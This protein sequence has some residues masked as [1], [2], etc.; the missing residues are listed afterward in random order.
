MVEMTDSTNPTR[1]SG[2]N[3]W[4]EASWIVLALVAISGLVATFSAGTP[5]GIASVDVFWRAVFGAS[6]VYVGARSSMAGSALAA[7]VG[8]LVPAGWI[9][10]LL[11]VVGLAGTGLGYRSSTTPQNSGLLRAMLGA[12]T[13][14]SLLRISPVGFHGL[15]ALVSAV[16]VTLLIVETQSVRTLWRHRVI[17]Q[18]AIGLAV[19]LGLFLSL[20]ALATEL[21]RRDVGSALAAVERGTEAVKD[22]DQELATTE[23]SNAVSRFGD[24]EGHFNS[25]WTQPIRVVPILNQHRQALVVAAAQGKQISA[26]T[27]A[28]AEAA[29]VDEITSGNGRIDLD[30][31]RALEDPVIAALATFQTARTEAQKINSPWLLSPVGGRL[32]E[33]IEEINDVE[34]DLNTAIQA[35]AQL[36]HILGGDGTR[37]Y[38]VIFGTP[39]EA[40]ELGGVIG[41]FAEIEVTDGVIRL[42][43]TGRNSDL[44][45]ASNGYRL[46]PADYPAR[47]VAL[48]PHTYAQNF[49]AS[50]DFPTVARAIAELYPNMGGSPIDGV[51]YLDPYALQALLTFTGPIEMDGVETVLD[52]E[53]AANFLLREQY[54]AFPDKSRRVDFLTEASKTAFERLLNADIPGPREIHDVLSPMVDQERLLFTTFVLPEVEWLNEFGVTGELRAGDSGDFLAVVNSNR[55]AN[56]LDAYMHRAIDYDVNVDPASGALDAKVTVELTNLVVPGLP[57]YVAGVALVGREF[58]AS[59]LDVSIYSPHRLTEVRIDGQIVPVEVLQE[60]GL[61]RYIVLAT[62]N[63]NQTVTVEFVLDGTIDPGSEYALEIATQPLVHDDKFSL[64]VQAPGWRTDPRDS[65]LLTG[66]FVLREKV[67]GSIFFVPDE[68]DA[69]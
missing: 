2:Q 53:T 38:L 12:V 67:Q 22:G 64:T 29:D 17:R 55:D 56:K 49:T 40:R 47:Y 21:G 44:N 6:L 41:N 33:L 57:E 16:L 15:S 23:L 27:L 25:W 69:G 14:Q 11:C 7:V 48:A 42:A 5:T 10:R 31:V 34:P 62:I 28:V 65:T 32:D 1:A 19:V 35:V 45:E 63:P 50:P 18:R 46:Q 24:A 20:F 9:W 13:A 4:F 3:G 36:P 68:I 30:Q 8:V 54:V 43:R 66:D 37:R 59:D 61:K 58:G 26:A 39:S 52:A 60:F 51:A